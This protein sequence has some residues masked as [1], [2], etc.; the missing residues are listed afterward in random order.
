MAVYHLKAGIGSRGGGQSAAAKNAYVCREGRYAGD[1]DE[2]LYREDG[3]MPRWAADEPGDYWQAADEHERANGSLYREVQFALPE[4]LSEDEQVALARD[5]AKSLT[6]NGERLPYTLAV[7]RGESREPD[8]PD[9]PHCHLVISERVNDGQGRS[10]ETWFKR[11][12]RQ[13]PEKGGARKS[14]AAMPREWLTNTR[15][16]WERRANQALERSG[17]PARID[18]RSWAERREDAMKRGDL[19]EAARCSREPNVHLGPRE[20]RHQDGKEQ[21]D[22]Q[23]KGENAAGAAARDTSASEI[24]E[25]KTAI[26]R[27]EQELQRLGEEIKRLAK[28]FVELARESLKIERQAAQRRGVKRRE[29]IDGRNWREAAGV[30]LKRLHE[31]Q[32]WEQTK[33]WRDEQRWYLHQQH[34]QQWI[35]LYERQEG[36]IAWLD[37][38][39]RTEEGR[40]ELAEEAVKLKKVHGE[41]K[42]ADDVLQNCKKE[43]EEMQSGRREELGRQQGRELETLG[44]QEQIDYQNALQDPLRKETVTKEALAVEFDR[45]REKVSGGGGF[46]RTE[47]TDGDFNLESIAQEYGIEL[48]RSWKREREREREIGPSR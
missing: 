46:G 42:G 7:H 5:F 6:T 47:R 30:A 19:E 8:E 26:E 9:N 16:E 11:H 33:P 29:F 38:R 18:R 3:N 23:V 14:R 31:R 15:Q 45:Q 34:R 21:K 44:E 43:L 12:N 20:Y 1:A 28:R 40:K 41:E 35:K 24:A 17:S 4:E 27:I 37:Q 32:A 22:Q 48:E 36:E 2:V 13:S 10:A 39:S 25:Q